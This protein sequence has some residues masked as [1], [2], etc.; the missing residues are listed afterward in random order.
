MT[1]PRIPRVDRVLAGLASVA[2]VAVFAVVYPTAS[3]AAFEG[4]VQLFN[5]SDIGSTAVLLFV[6]TS[7]LH[8]GFLLGSGW[9]FIRFSLV[10]DRVSAVVASGCALV[11]LYVWMVVKYWIEKDWEG[12]REAFGEARVRSEVVDD[13]V[14]FSIY[15]VPL[16]L[17]YTCVVGFA[18]SQLTRTQPTAT[19]T[20]STDG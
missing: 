3:E 18:R 8:L 19:P 20:T 17:L 15:V 6:V 10:A 1:K 14:E 2:L 9:V 11:S 7:L 4:L 13:L 5:P 12:Y 16:W